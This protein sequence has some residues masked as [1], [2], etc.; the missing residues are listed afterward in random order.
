M[1][2]LKPIPDDAE[3]QEL[4]WYV[5]ASQI[6]VRIDSAV[7]FGVGAVAVDQQGRLIAAMRA[8]PPRRIQSIP[9]AEAWAISAV[10]QATP[11][12]H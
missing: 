11:A 3:Y 1:E 2:W 4:D 5:D 8:I 9:S 7:R 10:L 12:I 6:D